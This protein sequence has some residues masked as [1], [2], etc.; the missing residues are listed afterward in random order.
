MVLFMRPLSPLPDVEAKSHWVNARLSGRLQFP[1]LVQ[2]EAIRQKFNTGIGEGAFHGEDQRAAR[3][4]CLSLEM[5]D[6]PEPNPGRERQ[7]L[8]LP[9]QQRASGLAQAWRE[10]GWSLGYGFLAAHNAY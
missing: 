5:P 8:L 2:S 10:Y 4:A 1:D 3:W 7:V 6:H 9:A